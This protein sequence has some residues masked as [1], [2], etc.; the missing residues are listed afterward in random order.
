MRVIYIDNTGISVSRLGFGTAS[1]HHLFSARKRQEL[2]HAAADLGIT[3]F[4]TSPYYGYGLCESDLGR[5]LAGHRAAFTLTTKVGLYPF[6]GVSSYAA[7]VWGRKA[8]GKLL[9]PISLPVV[10]WGI[11]RAR[12]SLKRSMQ[13]LGTDYIDFVL[14]HEP[15]LQ[16]IETDEFSRWLETEKSAGSIRAWGIAGV[17]ERI[18][19]FVRSN[20]M[21]AQVVQTQDSLHNQQADFMLMFGRKF[22]FTYGYFSSGA[23]CKGRSVATR[24]NDALSRNHTGC[25]LFSSR[26]I[27]RLHDLDG[28]GI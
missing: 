4:D 15:D 1:L 19:P 20:H 13:R 17:A 22:Q 21:L 12:E 25:V 9:P 3:H 7:S 6:G 18:V 23:S 10:D 11:K 27:D 26:R 5:F 14:L 24:L 16:L 2:L 28:I 8:I